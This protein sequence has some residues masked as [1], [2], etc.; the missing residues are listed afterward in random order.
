MLISKFKLETNEDISNEMEKAL[1]VQLPQ[2]YKIF[3]DRYN[4]GETPDTNWTGKGKTDVRGFYGYD[5]AND[6]WDIKEHRTETFLSELLVRGFLVIAE[7]SF[8]DMFC[9]KLEDETV[10]IAYHDS[11]KMVAI[12]D[13]F[14]KFINGCKSKKIG[15]ISTIEERKARLIANGHGDKLSENML[16]GWQEE[17]EK[18]S[19]LV[20][21]EVVI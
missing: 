4:G 6:Y 11:S 19:K 16:R 18:Y 12:A 1:C 14:E 13:D 5:N 2:K 3:I 9:M 8:G 10:W 20:Q 17:I 15:H 7:N 21:E